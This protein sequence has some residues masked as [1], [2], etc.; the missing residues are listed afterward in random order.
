MQIYTAC[1]TNGIAAFEISGDITCGDAGALYDALVDSVQSGVTTMI[2]ELSRVRRVTRSGLRGLFIAAKLLQQVHGEMRICGVN[3]SVQGS[4]RGQGFDHLLCF[5]KQPEI[6]EPASCRSKL[7]P[8]GAVP[9]FS[10]PQQW[11]TLS[12]KPAE[13]ACGS[14][15]TQTGNRG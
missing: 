9:R 8:A 7:R 3:R 10:V 13:A 1:K 4:L 14:N 11:P 5:H 15:P 6:A 2:V 12:Q